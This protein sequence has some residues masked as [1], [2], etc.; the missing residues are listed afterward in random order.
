MTISIG[1]PFYNAEAYLGDAIRSVF[2][3]SHSD[4]ELILVDDGS[5]DKSLEIARSV[6]DPRVRVISD[7]QNRRLPARLNQIIREARCKYIARM[8]ADDLMAP[9]RL[10]EQ[11]RVL[12][13]NPKID[14]VS[15]GICSVDNSGNPVGTRLASER[16]S[17]IRGRD[18]LRGRSPIVHAS[19]LARKSWCER[20]LYDESI[21][22]GQDYELWL[23]AFSN[24]D[25]SV[26][27][28]PK[29]YYYYRE[30]GNVSKE[31]L[32]R[33]YSSKIDLFRQYRH[34]GFSSFE[35][36]LRVF[37]NRLKKIAVLGLSLI[38]LLNIL[39][40]RRNQSFDSASDQAYHVNLIE[41]L[42]NTH[43]PGL[44]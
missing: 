32:T 6:R 7:G 4:W 23:R 29:P 11:L 36:E 34:L 38:G 13:E 12:V 2:A 14:L 20:N 3:Q 15:T 22:L 9:R 16:S 26:I 17:T 37:E 1:I 43:V 30:E 41:D 19:I 28:I 8:D 42:R 5:T 21:Y 35:C 40:E 33:I 10:E 18:L 24:N 27:C 31:R 39:L 25:L 44:D